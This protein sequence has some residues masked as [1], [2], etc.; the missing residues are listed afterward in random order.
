VDA[1]QVDLNWIYPQQVET[2][3]CSLDFAAV[4]T[5]MEVEDPRSTVVAQASFWWRGGAL[6]VERGIIDVHVIRCVPRQR[7]LAAEPC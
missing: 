7:R 4:V 5:E 1:L 6:L 3:L 2:N